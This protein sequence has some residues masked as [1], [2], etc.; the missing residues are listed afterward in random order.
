MKRY[1]GEQDN[2]TMSDYRD[3]LLELIRSEQSSEALKEKLFDYHDYDIAEVFP[4][5]SG[6]ERQ[7]LYSVLGASELSEIFAYLTDVELYLSEI[8]GLKVVDIID[9]MDADDAA[10]VLEQLSDEQSEAIVELLDSELKLELELIDSFD[11]A[12]LGSKMTTNYIVV[13]KNSTVKSAMRSLVEQAAENDNVQTIFVTD[14][15]ERFY[16]AVDLRNLITARQDTNFEDL[17]VTKYPFFMATTLIEDC[18]EELK[19]YSEDAIPLLDDDYK[20]IGVITASDVTE[21]VEEEIEEDYARLAGLTEAEDLKESI[22]KS[23]QKRAPWL[24]I[25]LGLGLVVSAVIERF[26]AVIP[27]TLSVIYTFQTLV[28]NMSGNTGTQSL[29]V[30][31]RVLS[32]GRVSGKEKLLFILK[33]LR[34]GLV[35]GAAIGLVA[36]GAIGCY[37]TFLSPDS[38]AH[39]GVSGFAISGC[40]GFS[41]TVAMAVASLNGTLIPMIFKKLGIDPAVA[42]GPLITTVNDLVAVCTYYG[43]SMMIFVSM[44]GLN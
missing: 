27:A 44:L 9:E 24:L 10:D 17:I 16:G 12:M 1:D 18:I 33:E 20:L 2:I 11:D 28:L 32:D 6:D 5:L 41:L 36:F 29:A 19:S 21:V 38:I 31:I 30:T 25:L 42:S 40:I 4:E 22:F 7:K 34:V 35:N 14:E 3:E 15:D 8:E 23:V 39:L 13:G 26:Y 43:L 37:L